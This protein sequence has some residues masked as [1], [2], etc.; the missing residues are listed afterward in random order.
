LN[1]GAGRIVGQDLPRINTAIQTK[2]FFNN[3]AFL[4][5]CKHV[6]ENH[7]KLHLLGLVSGGGVH[8]S[9][10]H[11]YALLGLAAAQGVQDIYIH[12]I[13]DG[14]DTAEKAA[15][16]SIQKLKGK[17]QEIGSTAKIATIT[18]RFYAMDRGNHWDQTEMTYQAMTNGIGSS[19]YTPE[20]C[21]LDNYNQGVYDEMIHPTVIV[22]ESPNSSELQPVSKVGDNDA[23]IFFNFRPD[24]AL[25]LTKAFVEPG[26]M[27]IS[28]KHQPLK[29]LYF[30]TMTEYFFGLPVYVAFPPTNLQNNLA[31]VI[32]R[33]N[34]KQFHI[35]ESEKYA[36]VTSF[37]NGGISEEFPGEERVIVDSP[38][39]THNYVDHPEMSGIELTDILVDKI[40][41]S[42]VNLFV[43]NFA[44]P[45]MV[46]HT[47]DLQASIKAVKY[48]DRFLEKI[49]EV[50]LAQDAAL[51][52]TAD[53][54]N[55]EQML[56]SKTGE[57]D[58]D[59]TT[60]PVPFLLIGNEFRFQQAKTR[61][62]LSLSA[63]TPDGVISD[64]APTI[65]ALFGLEKPQEMN[66]INLFDEMGSDNE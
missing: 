9:A 8:S 3:P 66:G 15:L 30:V 45:D 53:H 51:V 1:I 26:A 11:L 43:A 33:H 61:N 7:S 62:Y 22:K 36:H 13:T 24:R 16:E 2:E 32:S 6:K 50:I 23:V 5:A 55:I 64:I 12:M 41:N 25:Q 19:A 52:I 21:I 4:D 63:R 38:N 20:D 56:N 35:A 39:N 57:I 59:H 14:R 27:Q 17:I 54:G 46:G 42:D 28:S 58:K 10:E 34:L 44:N 37:F 40:G 31:E 48:L 60:N 65:L 49:M 29:N 47:G 18:G